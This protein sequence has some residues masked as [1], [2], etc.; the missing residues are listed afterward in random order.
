VAP[1]GGGRLYAGRGRR[2]VDEWLSL[3]WSPAHAGQ[4]AASARRDGEVVV[5]DDDGVYALTHYPYHAPAGFEW[6]HSGCGAAELARCIL[7]DHY[8]VVPARTGRL[9]RPVA[10][11]LP[12]DC[13]DFKFD[14]IAGLRRGHS[15]TLSSAQIDEWARGEWKGGPVI[16]AIA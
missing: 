15:W 5:F 16:G 7:L 13:R 11:E 10:G 6:G 4:L 8:A 14:V 9:C 2:T 1:G 3:G 12:V